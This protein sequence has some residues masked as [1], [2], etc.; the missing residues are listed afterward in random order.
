MGQMS[1]AA[2]DLTMAEALAQATEYRK[3]RSLGQWRAALLAAMT[4]T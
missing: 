1:A 2:L 3:A 4:E